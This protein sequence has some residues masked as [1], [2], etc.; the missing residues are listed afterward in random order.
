MGSGWDPRPSQD[1]PFGH[2]ANGTAHD[3]SKASFGYRDW[4][5]L[6]LLRLD[7][8]KPFNTLNVQGRCQ[9]QGCKKDWAPPV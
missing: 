5:F 6:E 1:F 4:S 2:Q 9:C 7:I 3:C 8:A